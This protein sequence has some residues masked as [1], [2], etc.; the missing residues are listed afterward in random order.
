M[1]SSST[2]TSGQVSYSLKLPD[3]SKDIK[4]P[5]LPVNVKLPNS[6]KDFNLPD[7]PVN[8]K[9][10]EVAEDVKKE[11]DKADGEGP[12]SRIAKTLGAGFQ[13]GLATVGNAVM[14][15]LGN[16]FSSG[17]DQ[18]N[19]IDVAQ[20]KMRGLGNDSAAV[21]KAT[22]NAFA[23]VQGTAFGVGDAAGVA[24]QLMAANI[25][26]GQQLES[27]LKTVGS[28]AAAA[29][30][31]F[32]TMGSIFAGA[33]S[34]MGGVQNDVLND[35]EGRGIPVYK[36]LADQLGVTTDEVFKMAANGQIS[37]GA[38]EQAAS[39]AAGAI[40]NEMGGT[41]TGSFDIMMGS[42][43]RLAMTIMEDVFPQI[44]P[45]FQE[46]SKW[47]DEAA[48]NVKPLAEAFGTWLKGALESAATAM[49]NVS[50]WL[51][52]N[53]T[54]VAPIAAAIGGA[55]LAFG[56]WTL[57]TEAAAAVQL[58][59]NAA[60]AA[61]P[62][63]LIVMAIAALVAGLVWF[64][65]Q[66]E[67]G[68]QIWEQFTGFLSEAWENVSG[69][70]VMVWETMLKP[71]LEGLGAIFTWIWLEIIQPIVD[72]I[73][74]AIQILGQVFMGLWQE[75]VQPVFDGLG[76]L[77]NWIWLE[78]I[79]P[80]VDNISVA[81]QIL[82]QVFM[83][84]WQE[85]VQ[86]V[87]DGLGL[88]F[89]WIWLEIIQPIVDNISVA[90]QILGQV[91]T[92]LWQEYIQPA[93]D[94]I[95]GLIRSVWEDHIK[96]VIDT[97]SSVIQSDPKKAFEAARDGIGKAWEGIQE[98]AKKP[99]RFVVNTV[100]NGLIDM[101]NVIPGV[102]LAPI[103]LPKGFSEGGYTGNLPHS[104][105][106]GVVHGNEHVIRAASRR[107]IERSHPGALDHM[108]RFGE[109]PG[110]ASGGLVNPLKKGS[111]NVSQP[112]HGGHNGIDL[113]AAEGTPIMAA[114]EG[115][116][117]NVGV[118]NMGGKEIRLQHPSGFATRYSHLSRFAVHEGQSVQQ[119]NVIGYVGSTGMS[120]G[121]HL[122]YMVHTPPGGWNNMTDPA[123]YLD[124]SAKMLGEAWNPLAGL[125]DWVAGKVKE[126]FPE[127]GMWIDAAAGL[128]KDTAERAVKLFTP[129]IG[130]DG[131][132]SATLYDT[133]G[134]L[135]PGVS[136]VENRTGRP[137]PILTGAQ[138]DAMKSG[139]GE[140][141]DQVTLLD[142]DGSILT[143]AR[144]IADDA[145]DRGLEDAAVMQRQ[146]V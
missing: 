103:K 9:V 40:S 27:V 7:V 104:A 70:F 76:L 131:S 139:S 132:T 127:G 54:W 106:A 96:P 102:N 79:Q 146:Y 30:T 51:Q 78:I 83:G 34:Q 137:E 85:H 116:A 101:I 55:A 120:T 13:K 35:L 144:V 41:A 15:T 110:Y 29:G 38:F 89:N 134:W 52:D 100:L 123:P 121:P 64:F 61:N 77:F 1:A 10:P 111:Y 109:I 43:E 11:L 48:V 62:I 92:G 98:L 24:G 65:T 71:V 22:D 39:T 31:D 8:V 90:I 80:I 26:P 46:I 49:Q 117:T 53:Y 135:Q 126:A 12:G 74:V 128:V 133:G 56:A 69:L 3:F 140:F 115:V 129:R 57:A 118:V 95:S 114:A 86:P 119:G 66:T 67:L 58:L 72:N 88:L 124:G 5:D 23:A 6:F 87:F 82:G 108:N 60:L 47:L 107:Q 21:A 84:L 45:V 81:I 136:L 33:A 143:R 16:A 14:S 73:S 142:A 2:T 25:A 19:A 91:F 125:I 105:V 17:V 75:H 122:H 28:S 20:A 18:L 138:W 36:A 32:G 37:F 93:W 68:K 112:F 99:V 113:A 94:G 63:M 42:L 130:G 145:V 141:P 4:L 59:Y 50:K 44:A 97:M